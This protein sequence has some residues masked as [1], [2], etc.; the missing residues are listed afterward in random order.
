MC[1]V[2]KQR[3]VVSVVDIFSLGLANCGRSRLLQ[4]GDVPL[5]C[6][7]VLEHRSEDLPRETLL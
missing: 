5:G 3:A 2:S 7:Q 1:S 4:A 6:T